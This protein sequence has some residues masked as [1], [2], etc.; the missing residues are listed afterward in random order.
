MPEHNERSFMAKILTAVIVDM[1][2]T[3]LE[4]L[5]AFIASTD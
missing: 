1:S 5:D 4:H 3:R 2:A